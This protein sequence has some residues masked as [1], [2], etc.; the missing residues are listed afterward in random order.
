[1]ERKETT[2]SQLTGVEYTIT[3]RSTDG[4][5]GTFWGQLRLKPSD[6]NPYS[7]G[8]LLDVVV[9]VPASEPSAVTEGTA[10]NVKA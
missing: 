3:I 4:A 6:P 1:M 7:L 8:Q 2:Y 9:Q 10:A 5:G